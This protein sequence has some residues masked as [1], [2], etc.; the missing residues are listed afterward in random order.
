MGK[1]LKK[2]DV[3]SV[4]VSINGHLKVLIKSSINFIMELDTVLVIYCGWHRCLLIPYSISTFVYFLTF[5]Y[6]VREMGMFAYWM[7][8]FE[9]SFH[10][11]ILGKS[12]QT[13]LFQNYSS[14]KIL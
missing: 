10:L 9:M 7:Y 3:E 6:A 12:Q 2:L 14:P 5:Y 1:L 4:Q 8:Q 13:R 11:C